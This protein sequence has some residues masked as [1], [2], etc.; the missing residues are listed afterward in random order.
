MKIPDKIL[1][2]IQDSKW[3]SLDEMK[4]CLYFPSDKLNELLNFLENQSFINIEK[5]RV[6]ITSLGL[7]FL[8]L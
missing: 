2:Q 5:D 4:K 8:N 7:K 1:I 3:H 6:K